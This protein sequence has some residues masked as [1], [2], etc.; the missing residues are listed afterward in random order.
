MKRGID[1]RKIERGFI[2]SFLDSIKT[3]AKSDKKTIVLPETGDM[4]TLNAAHTIL[5]EELAN[6]ILIG[7]KEEILNK[8]NGLDLSK[9]QIVD[10][11]TFEEMN[12]GFH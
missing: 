7:N 6:L 4:R 5:K 3:R 9:A 2:M 12:K 1:K 11:Q 8:A 10:P